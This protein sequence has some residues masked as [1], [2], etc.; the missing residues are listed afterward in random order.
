MTNPN[1]R[2]SERQLPLSI[3]GEKFSAFA[4]RGKIIKQ[5]SIG[6]ACA[7]YWRGIWY[8]I[9][10]NLFPN[11]KFYSASSSLALGTIGLGL[12]QSFIANRV[13]NDM[14]RKEVGL[15]I[16]HASTAARFGALYC[17]STSCVLVWRGSWLLWDI[18]Y[19][20]MFREQEFKATDPKHLTKSGFLSHF[21]ASV[22]LL[23]FGYFTSALAPPARLTILR[24]AKHW[25]VKF[26]KDFLK[27]GV[28]K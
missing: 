19:E 8:I 13:E 24:D 18:L 6:I 21:C 23:T 5:V 11:N 12:S 17:V 14:M 25:Q 20:E 3:S 9:D 10:D 15:P 27:A 26:W 22:G 4:L 1:P 7:S 2:S 28:K 16:R